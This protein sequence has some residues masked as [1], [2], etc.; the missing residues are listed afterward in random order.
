MRRICIIALLVILPGQITAMEAAAAATDATAI[1]P[2]AVG[3]TLPAAGIQTIDGDQ[4]T[5][6]EALGG[7]PHLLIVYRGGWCPYC[8]AHL[9]A[10][11]GIAEE[12]QAA[13]VSL[14]ALA[15][16]SPGTLQAGRE[17]GDLA[18]GITYLSD[19]EAAA[20]RALGLAFTVDAD[21]RERY[22]GYG[23]DLEAA[24]GHDHHLLPVPAVLLSDAEGVVRFVH[25]D[26]DYKR[27][28]DPQVILAL[29]RSLG[30]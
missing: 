30:R 29:A 19:A 23:I 24:S 22:R 10:V 6:Q 2:I 1:R 21:T 4:T 7:A 18:P 27:R 14:I 25:P 16:D 5:L 13:G 3:S 8:N 26:P 15:P 17:A 20:I 11:A 9:G 12:L 28:L